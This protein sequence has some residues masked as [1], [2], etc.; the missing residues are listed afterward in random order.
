MRFV[1]LLFAAASIVAAWSGIPAAA[2]DGKPQVTSLPEIPRPIHEALQDERFDD[3]LKL[4]DEAIA[5]PKAA[6]ADYLLY[7]KGRAL[8]ELARYDEA[9]QTFARLEKDHPESRWVARARFGRADTFARQRNYSEAGLIYQAEAER[10]LSEDR[11][12][13]LAGIYLEFA[14]RYFEGVPVEGPGSRKQPDYQQAL[15]YYQEALRV[16]PGLDLEQKIELRIARS[17]Q[18][19]GQHAEAIAAYQ[20]FVKEHASD[21][22]PDARRAPVQMEVEARFRLAEAQL[23]AGQP[24]E[25]RKTWE[26]FLADERMQEHGG[27]F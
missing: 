16:R 25:A 11:R 23:A 8:T 6:A 18:E 4:I 2:E 15:T 20:Q 13:E 5:K 21:D 10:L 7:L 14:D 1:T 26:D 17:Y 19:L 12:D 24:A 3:A 9:R 27:D 22:T